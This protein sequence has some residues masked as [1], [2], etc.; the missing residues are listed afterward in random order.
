MD[1]K[2]EEIKIKMVMKLRGVTRASAVRLI[3]LGKE[4]VHQKELA[5]KTSG[6][7]NVVSA[8]EDSDADGF[9]SAEEFFGNI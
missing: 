3:R 9:I 6:S 4:A 2:F 5:R 8:K 7:D 1:K